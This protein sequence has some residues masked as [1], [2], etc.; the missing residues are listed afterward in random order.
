MKIG[1]VC[2]YN[3]FKGGGVQECVIA[4]KEQLTERGH[5]VRIVTP[6]PRN[7]PETY[8]NEILLVGTATDVKSPF[9]TTAQVSATVDS[10]S[11]IAMLERENFDVLHFH[12][13]W[14]PLISWQLLSRSNAA[15]VATFH[16]KLPESVMSRTI[17]RVIT[18]YTKSILKSLHV[19]TAVSPA[20]SEY[21][22]SLS[23]R[24]PVIIPNGI[25]LDKYTP[26]RF[27][28]PNS[29][30]RTIVYVG[31]LERRKG[32]KYLLAAFKQLHDTHKDTRLILIG[33]GPD[34]NKLES[35]VRDKRID[36]VDFRGYLP[37][38]EK[39]DTVRNAD[40]FCSPALYGESFGIVL[41]EAMALGTAVVAGNNPGYSAV[42][43]GG[44]EASIVNPKKTVQFAEKLE[45][46][47]SD[48]KLRKQWLQWARRSVRQYN[49][50]DITSEYE[51]A[52]KHA[53]HN[54]SVN[55][56]PEE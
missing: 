12:E 37:E 39:I 35:F 5:D 18:P 30:E 51:R 7:V 4:L 55:E 36:N 53:L 23:S 34:R 50:K 11:L 9:H 31:R 24:N 33:D 28:K 43:R 44:G 42:L 47:L 16:A 15:H 26:K 19:L 38:Q 40:I 10:T 1:L 21:V 48:E 54:K 56:D 29:N 8:D 6:K 27:L 32:V 14:V 46:F 3:I 13:P 22:T 17:E 49:Y 25:D 2:P 52:Y 45:Q 20:A 41:L